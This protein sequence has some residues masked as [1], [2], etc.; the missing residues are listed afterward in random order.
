MVLALGSIFHYPLKFQNLNLILWSYTYNILYIYSKVWCSG[1]INKNRVNRTNIPYT[2][3]MN[4][5]VSILID[6]IN[7]RCVDPCFQHPIDSL[8]WIWF[9]HFTFFSWSYFFFFISPSEA[10]FN[11]LNIL[12]QSSNESLNYS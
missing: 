6:F 11:S 1:C 12:F 10:P 9:C 7:L 5:V 2:L 4:L 8:I 3:I